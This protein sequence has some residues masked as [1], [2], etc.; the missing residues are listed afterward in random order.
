MY[1]TKS[2]PLCRSPFLEGRRNFEWFGDSSPG[3]FAARLLCMSL[4]ID[5]SLFS[6]TLLLI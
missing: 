5:A 1:G 4:L 3:P 6:L 2:V